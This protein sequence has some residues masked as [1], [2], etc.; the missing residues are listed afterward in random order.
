MN[1]RQKVTSGLLVP[2][3]YPSVLLHLGPEPFHQVPILIT[4][5]VD[6]TLD[7]AVRPRRDHC[8]PALRLDRLHQGL[9]VETPVADHDLERDVRDQLRGLRP[10]GR[11]ARRPDQ[12]D[13]PPPS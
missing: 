3:R 5:A 1:Q 6:R 12:L 7:L 9:A 8:L 4:V 11:L 2:G 13:W 10:V